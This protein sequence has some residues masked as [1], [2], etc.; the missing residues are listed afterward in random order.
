MKAQAAGAQVP[1]RSDAAGRRFRLASPATANA[2]G[3]LVVV[4]LAVTVTLAGLIHQ[5]TILNVSTGLTIPLIY[6]AV[7]VVVARLSRVTRWAGY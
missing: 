1:E 3:A 2:L 6:G 5:L 7:G 4:L